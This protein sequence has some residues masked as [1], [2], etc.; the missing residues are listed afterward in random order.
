MSEMSFD[1]GR[2]FFRPGD[3]AERAYQIIEGRVEMTNGAIRVAVRGPGD[4]F[5][6]MSLIEETPHRLVARALTPGRCT[7]LTR[8]EFEQS[9]FNDPPRAR[10]Y[11]KT[12]FERLRAMSAQLGTLPPS[13]GLGEPVALPTTDG[14]APP[15]VRVVVYPLTRRAAQTLPEDGLIINQFPFR[16]G[17]APGATDG[18]G[19]DL[20]DLWLLDQKPFH[21]SR[22]HLQIDLDP[23]GTVVI[24]DRGSHLG[25]EVNDVPIGG[26]HPTREAKLHP[27]QNVLVV[28]GLMSPYQF[29]VEVGG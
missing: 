9:L 28:G 26:K 23:D 25:C 8:E 12:L 17:R 21:V 11:L 19:M 27:G 24:R 15:S 13:E 10:Q 20:N 16:I 22:N 3:P 1:A 29:R 7:T 14:A 6:E 18:D 4:V 2:I 5:G